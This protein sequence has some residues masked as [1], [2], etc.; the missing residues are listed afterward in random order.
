MNDITTCSGPE[1]TREVTQYPRTGLCNAHYLQQSRGKPLKKLRATQEPVCK[2]PDCGRSSKAHSLCNAH[3]L[4]Y[5]A[6]RELKRQNRARGRVLAR[7]EQ[8][9]KECQ[10]CREWKPESEYRP[11]RTTPDGLRGRCQECYRSTYDPAAQRARS[12]KRKYNMSVAEYESLVAEQGDSCAICGTTDKRGKSWHVD[13]DHS[14]CPGDSSCGQCVRG[15]LCPICNQ[16][17]GM[18]RDDVAILTSMI[19]YLNE[20]SALKNP[21]RTRSAA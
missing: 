17:L 4:Q 13:H 5:R 2:F 1:C 19:D 11:H 20:R 21:T 3:Y 18:V 10:L 14:C 8:G 9:R 6:G 7:D 12:L 15:L 16:A